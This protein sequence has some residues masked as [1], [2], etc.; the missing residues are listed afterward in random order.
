MAYGD[1]KI[2]KGFASYSDI[3]TGWTAGAGIEHAISDR[4]TMRFEYRY[5]DLG[6]SNFSSTPANSIDKSDTEFHALRAGFSF[7][8]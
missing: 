4:M 7:K 3:R 2:D 8:F 5:T 1:V 6:T